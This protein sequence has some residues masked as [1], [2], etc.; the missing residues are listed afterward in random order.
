MQGRSGSIDENKH[1]TN[2]RGKSFFLFVCST[3]DVFRRRLTY[4][5]TGGLELDYA[6]GR[7]RAWNWKDQET[8]VHAPPF[9]PIVFGM[10]QYL[11][12]RFMTQES[13]ALTLTG[14]KRSCRFNVG[15]KLKVKR[16]FSQWI[17]MN[18]RKS[19]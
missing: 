17:Y 9:Q 3:F 18:K 16:L 6:G 11:G 7:R 4:D 14:R 5:P 8:H 12:I 15:A 2:M 10:N 1:S 13:L 19:Q